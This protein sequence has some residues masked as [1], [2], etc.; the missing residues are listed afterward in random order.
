[1]HSSLG[2]PPCLPGGLDLRAHLRSFI[3]THAN[4][5]PVCPRFGTV[6]ITANV[7][8]YNLTHWEGKPGPSP[9]CIPHGECDPTH[10]PCVSGAN[11][12]VVAPA[13][14]LVGLV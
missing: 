2:A 6:L 1:M 13:S 4:R 7:A 10:T 5:S 9:Y 8:F 12:S 11:P 14:A 3:P